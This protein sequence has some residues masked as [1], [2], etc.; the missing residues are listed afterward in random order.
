MPCGETALAGSALRAAGTAQK[1]QRGRSLA[2]GEWGRH[3]AKRPSLMVRA[4]EAAKERG[5]A[6]PTPTPAVSRKP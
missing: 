4:L 1:P 6:L 5:L 3:R 2:L